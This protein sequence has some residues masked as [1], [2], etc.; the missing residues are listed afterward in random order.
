MAVQN[1]TRITVKLIAFAMIVFGAII[2]IMGV[3]FIFG[4]AWLQSDP[5]LVQETETS[6]GFTAREMAIGMGCFMA[7]AVVLTVGGL[8]GM[9]GGLF[10]IRTANHPE[11]AGPAFATGIVTALLGVALVL[12]WSGRYLLPEMLGPEH[13]HRL[14]LTFLGVLLL[15]VLQAAPGLL[16]STGGGM[17]MGA[18]YEKTRAL[19]K[20]AREYPIG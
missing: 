18:T 1:S 13:R 2:F 20:A 11:N 8:I 15:I 17:P 10:G 19:I 3:V 4:V 14:L 16:V 5:A 6:L 7:G 9:L 12:A